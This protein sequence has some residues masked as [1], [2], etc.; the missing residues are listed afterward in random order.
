VHPQRV[1]AARCHVHLSTAFR[2]RH[3]FL[4]LVDHLNTA[5]LTGSVEAD[6]TMFRDSF[7]GQRKIAE[8][9]VRK[10]GNDNNKDAKWVPVLVAKLS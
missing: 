5:V 3:R 9:P 7:K 8:R 1:T 10:R 2:W 4:K 6:Q